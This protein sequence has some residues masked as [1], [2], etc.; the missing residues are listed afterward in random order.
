MYSK[1]CAY[2]TS[3]CKTKTQLTEQLF[4]PQKSSL[5]AKLDFASV[6]ETI[7]SLGSDFTFRDSSCVFNL[8]FSSASVSDESLELAQLENESKMNKRLFV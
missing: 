1:N 7:H 6:G 3:A 2:G 5:Y 8:V 4:L